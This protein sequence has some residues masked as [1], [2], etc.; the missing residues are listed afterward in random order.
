MIDGA[1]ELSPRCYNA[2]GL[3]CN[4][5]ESG[6]GLRTPGVSLQQGKGLHQPYLQGHLQQQGVATVD[7]LEALIGAEAPRAGATERPE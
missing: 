2:T 7:S 6:P 5:F 4:G 3:T 1:G